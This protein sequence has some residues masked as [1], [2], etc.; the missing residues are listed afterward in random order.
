MLYLVDQSSDWRI[1]NEGKQE[2]RRQHYSQVICWKGRERGA[3]SNLM[4]RSVIAWEDK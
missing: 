4:L 3:K 1:G 2:G